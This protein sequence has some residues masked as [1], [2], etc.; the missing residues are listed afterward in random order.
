MSGDVRNVYMH[1]C[2]F[3]GTDRAVRI[4]SR[5]DRGGVVEHVWAERLRV[6][7]MQQDVVIMNMDYTA[8]RNAPIAKNP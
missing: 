5:R 6:R 1:D 7:N 4:K 2:E 8:D 3:D